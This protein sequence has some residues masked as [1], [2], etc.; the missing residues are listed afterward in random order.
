M[1]LARKIGFMSDRQV[2]VMGK[3]SRIF[4]PSVWASIFDDS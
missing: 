1:T 3:L 2:T 4:D